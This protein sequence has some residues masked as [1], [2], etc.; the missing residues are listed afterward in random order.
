MQNSICSKKKHFTGETQKYGHLNPTSMTVMLVT[1]Q[2]RLLSVSPAS[3]SGGAM[4]SCCHRSKKSQ[5]SDIFQQIVHVNQETLRKETLVMLSHC[6]GYTPPQLRGCAADR[7][8]PRLL[9]HLGRLRRRATG[10][11]A[12]HSSQPPA[13]RHL[14]LFMQ[15]AD[16]LRVVLVPPRRTGLRKQS[17]T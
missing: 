8:S 10:R 4:W 14:Q 3:L 2:S 5:D 12:G 13:Y 1:F 16:W 11:T 15:T 7:V 9:K 6:R 17:S